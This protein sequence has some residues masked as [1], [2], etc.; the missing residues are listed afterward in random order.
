MPKNK[1]SDAF[2]MISYLIKLR[3]F[4]LCQLK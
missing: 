1:H 4:T 2:I 3:K